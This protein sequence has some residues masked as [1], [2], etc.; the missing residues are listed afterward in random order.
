M[1]E[2]RPPLSPELDALLAHEREIVPLPA[3]TR[4]RSLARARAA[5]ADASALPASRPVVAQ[6]FRWAV[7][8]AIVCVAG[9]AAAAVAYQVRAR[10]ASTPAVAAVVAS[11]AP[12]PSFARPDHDDAPAAAPEAS[13]PT[14][15]M[16]RPSGA[17]P[18]TDTARIELSLMGQA[19]AAVARG[20]YAAALTPIAEHTRRFKDGLLAEEREALRVKALAGL[21]RGREAARAASAFRVRFPRSVLLPAVQQMSGSAAA[22]TR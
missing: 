6:P 12:A 17:L 8:A 1:N 11:P 19:R 18:P 16:V 20:D 3:T 7:A 2:K 9:G 21:G 15:A 5:L 22:R 14:R 4:A 13:P 10:R